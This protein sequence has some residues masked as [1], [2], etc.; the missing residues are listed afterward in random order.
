[1]LGKVIHNSCM[2]IKSLLGV[3][4]IIRV[5]SRIVRK[6]SEKADLFVLGNGISTV[7]FLKKNVEDIQ[8]KDV[9]CVNSFLNTEWFSVIKPR[10]CVL[11]DPLYFRVEDLP[12]HAQK[13]VLQTKASLL[14][15]T[16]WPLY[17]YVPHYVKHSD[18][19][20]EMKANKNI[21][22]TY[23][24]LVSFAGF[25]SMKIFL[26]RR[27]LCMPHSK[28]VL[29][30]SLFL[31]LFLGYS[32]IYLI[33][34]E[35]DWAKTMYV[36]DKNFV[37]YKPGHFYDENKENEIFLDQ[38]D[39]PDHIGDVLEKLAL[40]FRGYEEVAEMTACFHANIYNITP[41]SFI[42]AF[43]RANIDAWRT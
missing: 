34:G 6:S 38:T 37:R 21:K 29:V 31:S 43:P 15:K 3:M 28:N 20:K 17:L 18:F 36:D 1:M 10:Y 23:I 14:E 19:S 26:M 40:M 39:Q 9:L 11:I 30:A 25:H 35:H 5:H 8:Y 24:P 2:V 27:G 12:K 13:E 7:G 33:G 16:N 22:L 32:N 42:D 41:N 4:N